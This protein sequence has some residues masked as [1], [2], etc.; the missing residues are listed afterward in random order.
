MDKQLQ[1]LLRNYTGDPTGENAIAFVERYRRT[2]SLQEVL[3]ESITAAELYVRSE[4][5]DEKGGGDYFSVDEVVLI[6]FSDILGE[7][8]F[9]PWDDFYDMLIVSVCSDAF[10]QEIDWN[11]VGVG[12]DNSLYIQVT[13]LFAT[14]D[15]FD[16]GP[17]DLR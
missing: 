3:P 8:T 9:K 4:D 7:A 11:V 14:D 6:S 15:V 1:S 16:D 12:K 13:G 17:P 5:R 10:F 2:T